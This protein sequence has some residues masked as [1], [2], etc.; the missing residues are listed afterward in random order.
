ME[1]VGYHAA[2]APPGRLSVEG[3]LLRAALLARYGRRAPGLARR[4]AAATEL[5]T[6]RS[7]LEAGAPVQLT[8][9][10]PGR[11][12]L[13][14]GVRLGNDVDALGELIAEA[15]R[16]HLARALAPLPP[17][18]HASLGTWLFW[19]DLR[20]SIF[21]DLRDPDPADALARLRP[22]LDRDQRLRLDAWRQQLVGMRPWA[23]RLEADDAGLHRVHLHW[24]LQRHAVPAT[25]A[26]AI[27][28]GHWPSVVEALGHLLRR[29]GVSGRW[30]MVT[31]LDGHSEPGL[32]VGNTGWTLVP[33][34]DRKHRAIARLMQHLGGDRDHAE[35]LWSMCRGSAGDQW[36]VG[37]ACEVR[38]TAGGVRIRLFL[39][40]RIQEGETAG[41][42]N[43]EVF[44]S[45]NGDSEA[46]PSSP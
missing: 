13:R 8:L 3:T 16:Q 24:L 15:P 5:G 12:G 27:A 18:A 32:R 33:E 37:R 43:S 17:A 7:C 4:L 42:S 45:T 1:G 46:L 20:Q 29:P 39:T 34:D 35:A 26:E 23:L 31:P 9:D 25:A 21:V 19:T 28:P 38:C 41:T 36:R 10:A 2:G 11:R 14:A 40:P 44:S 22:V 30:T 6:S